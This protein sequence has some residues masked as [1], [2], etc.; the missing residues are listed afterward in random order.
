MQWIGTCVN[1]GEEMKKIILLF[2]AVLFLGA[3]T[4]TGT[5]EETTERMSR[6][7]GENPFADF[8]RDYSERN[9]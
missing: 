1:G 8:E 3:C 9:E 7:Y 2:I 6:G 4:N 5:T